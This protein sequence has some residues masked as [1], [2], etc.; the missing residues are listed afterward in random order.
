MCNDSCALFLHFRLKYYEAKIQ[1]LSVFLWK[2]AQRR[3]VE[4]K[5]LLFVKA[6]NTHS[7]GR[8]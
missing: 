7:N 4:I 2:P 3:Y 1:M 6:Y 8:R 5:I